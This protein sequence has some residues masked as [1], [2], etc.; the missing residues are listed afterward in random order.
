MLCMHVNSSRWKAKIYQ[1]NGTE[2]SNNN[3]VQ[4]TTE[5]RRYVTI[6]SAGGYVCTSL[7]SRL[8]G[9]FFYGQ[10]Q[11]GQ[12][13]F[14]SVF[15]MNTF[16]DSLPV[17]FPGGLRLADTRA[18]PFRILSQLRVMEVVV[19]TE[20]TR[21]A[22]L[23]QHPV[24]STGRMPFLSPNQQC[25]STEGN[26]RAKFSRCQVPLCGSVASGRVPDL[27]SIGRGFE[28]QPPRRR[29]QPWASC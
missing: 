1:Y 14:S 26:V 24:F 6:H 9:P 17:H 22:K 27:R 3:T 29:V 10:K 5:L 4:R 18:S 21:R 11:L 23:N 16:G 13:P 2:S 28:S 19:T 12:E 8:T 20:A 15:P 7:H 25:Q